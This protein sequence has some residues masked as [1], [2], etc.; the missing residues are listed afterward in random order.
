MRGVREG[1]GGE[2]GAM[3]GE[4]RGGNGG[5]EFSLVDEAVFQSVGPGF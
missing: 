3:V 4:G 5:R 1:R 2:G